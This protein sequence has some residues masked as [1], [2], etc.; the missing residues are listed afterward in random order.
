MFSFAQKGYLPF[1]QQI[2]G[3]ITDAPRPEVNCRNNVSVAY[4]CDTEQRD[5]FIDVDYCAD[6][7]YLGRPVDIYSKL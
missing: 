2:R 7:D 4:V 1:S 5:L 3:G 6:V